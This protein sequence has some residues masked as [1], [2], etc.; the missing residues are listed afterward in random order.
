MELVFCG[1]DTKKSIVDLSKNE[2]N[3]I[4]LVNMCPYL[5]Y[6]GQKKLQYVPS[7]KV[8]ILMQF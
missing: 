1:F 5:F 8:L 3:V 6:K 4:D 7:K 2:D